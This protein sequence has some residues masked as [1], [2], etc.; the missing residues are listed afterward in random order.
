MELA[1]A[2]ILSFQKQMHPKDGLERLALSQILMAHARTAWLTK[3]LAAETEATT[4]AVISEAAERASG[5][6]ARL[7]RAIAEYRQPKTSHATVSIGQANLAGQEV[8]QKVERQEV[9]QTKCQ[10]TK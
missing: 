5:T 6:F 1:L 7:T 3:L 10:R 8:I 4:L 9:H 2:A